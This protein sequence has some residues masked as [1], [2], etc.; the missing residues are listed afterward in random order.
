MSKLPLI[1]P[2]QMARILKHL[3][4]V[5]IRQKGSHA[6]FQHPDS[7]TT[8]LPMHKGDDLGR[9][10]I[11]SILRDIDITPAEYGRLRRKI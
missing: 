11:R 5:L 4:F 3:G 1:S 2:I 9:G 7:R 10:L 6:Y 8:V